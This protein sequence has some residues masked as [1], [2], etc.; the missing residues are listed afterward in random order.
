VLGGIIPV[1]LA[2]GRNNDHLFK[3]FNV[4]QVLNRPRLITSAAHLERLGAFSAAHGLAAVFSNI[5]PRVL[6]VEEIGN[7]AGGQGEVY[8]RS[9][10]TWL[11]CS[12]RRA[13][14]ERPKG[15]G[16]PTATLLVNTLAILQGINHPPEGDLSSLGCR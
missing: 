12:F 7:G 16:S 2:I 1:P 10:T 6:R 5:E 14:P 11:T 4:W 3:V 15:Y 9:P 8:P 13:P